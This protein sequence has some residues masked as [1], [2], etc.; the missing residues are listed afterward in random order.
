MIID[1]HCHISKEYYNDIENVINSMK[2]NI[3]IISGYNY[4]S[5]KEVIEIINKY[6]NVYGTI[7]I[8]PGDVEE[9][10]NISL[11]HLEE[12]IN[13]SKIVG[14]GEIGLDYHYPNID[15]NKQKE[16]FEKQII[17]A[18]KYNKTIVI[19]SRDAYEDTYNILNENVYEDMKLVMHCYGYSKESA[20]MLIRLP[21]KDIKFGI[22]GVITFKN[23]RKLRETVEQIGIEY[24]V[25]ETDSPYLSPE[26]Y[27]GKQNVPKNIYLIAKKLAE[28][29]NLSE[30][31]VINKTT[32]SALLQFDLE[33]II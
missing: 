17:L 13:H 19:H 22:G 27:R 26:P 14:I 30:D 29:L 8:H 3:I 9:D 28:I 4:E 10:M 20:M 18:K 2:N 1:T 15:K 24:I 32:K 7:G 12:N 16:Y 33:D 25:L 23:E 6:D 31:D 21:I 11:K 5:N